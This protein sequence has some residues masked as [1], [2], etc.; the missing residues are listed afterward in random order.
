MVKEHRFI[1]PECLSVPVYKHEVTCIED[2]SH[3][4]VTEQATPILVL[5]CCRNLHEQMQL[6]LQQSIQKVNQLVEY[7]GMSYPASPAILWA[8]IYVHDTQVSNR[9]LWLHDNRQ[10]VCCGALAII[11]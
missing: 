3:S 4:A 8:H 2:G 1:T 7:C 11:A 6:E 9:Q 5:I 10:D